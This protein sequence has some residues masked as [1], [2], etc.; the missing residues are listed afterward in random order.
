MIDELTFK[1]I[2][3]KLKEIYEIQNWWGEYSDF[4]TLVAVILSQATERKSNMLAF[5]NLRKKMDMNPESFMNADDETI[6]ECIKVA[7]LQNTKAYYI[8]KCAKIIHENY[9]G[10]LKNI[11]CL[12]YEEARKKLMELPGVGEKTADILLNFMGNKDVFPVDT[13]IYRI[14]KK[15]NL[16]SEGA[17]YEEVKSRFEEMIQTDDRRFMHLALIEFG[18]EYCKAKNPRCDA[19]P[20]NEYCEGVYE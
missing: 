13:H 11:L 7:G 1:K 9:E 18:R 19:C 17:N 10:D 8:K 12:E 6:K 2:T 3:E 4:E 5:N 16:V 20:M 15:W 14:A